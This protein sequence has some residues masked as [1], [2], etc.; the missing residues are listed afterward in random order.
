MKV[1]RH[2]LLIFASFLLVFIW[3]NTEFS[4]Y[5]IPLIGFLIFLFLIISIRNKM[6]LNLGGPINFFILNTVLLLFI[7]STGGLSSNLF[8]ILYFLLFAA[9]FIMD[10]RTVFIFP[11]GVIVIF[12]SQIFTGDVTSNLIKIASLALLTP[13]S[14]FFGKQFNKTRKQDDEIL[15]TKERS[16]EAGSE[17]SKDTKEVLQT[18]GPK[19]NPQEKTK[20]KDVLEEADDLRTETEA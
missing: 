10:P 18:A 11:V 14:Y 8:F 15:K 17:I 19:L 2:A 20:L 9:S 1:Y 3:E 12:W 6:N 7:F 13:L 5:T 4:S 16:A